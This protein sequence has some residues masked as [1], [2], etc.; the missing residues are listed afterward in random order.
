MPNEETQLLRRMLESQKEVERITTETDRSN[1]REAFLQPFRAALEK[2]DTKARATGQTADVAA[3]R[4]A[5]AN[6]IAAQAD[7]DKHLDRHEETDKERYASLRSQ[8]EQAQREEDQTRKQI[9][10][11]IDAHSRNLATPRIE[12]DKSAAVQRSQGEVLAPESP[13]CRPAKAVG[14]PGKKDAG[15]RLGGEGWQADC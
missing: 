14:H 13:S 1:R 9:D 8:L 11:M 5:K 12:R 6:L 15:R 10:G 3:Y 2:A 4:R 7:A